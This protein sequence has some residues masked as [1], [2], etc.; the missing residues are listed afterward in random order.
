LTIFNEIKQVFKLFG[1]YQKIKSI[2]TYGAI[3]FISEKNGVAG[4]L[5]QEL[6]GLVVVHC[7][8]HRLNLGC[9]DAW[10]GD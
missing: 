4:R 3:A 1:L 2:S 7:I 8:S 10:E 9:S 6:P 5:A